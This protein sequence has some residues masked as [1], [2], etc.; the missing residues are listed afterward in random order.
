MILKFT[1]RIKLNIKPV[2]SSIKRKQIKRELNKKSFELRQM[3]YDAQYYPS[4]KRDRDFIYYSSL[5]IIAR[6][7]YTY[8]CFVISFLLIFFHQARFSGGSNSS[9]Y[10]ECLKWSY[11][12]VS[13]VNF[14]II[15]AF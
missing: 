5:I 11:T 4:N 15:L 7:A 8:V 14:L 9:K 3:K 2:Y 1:E 13:P 12:Y 6:I 10:N